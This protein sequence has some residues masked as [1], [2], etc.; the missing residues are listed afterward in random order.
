VRAVVSVRTLP[1]I[2]LGY[3]YVVLGD[4]VASAGVRIFFLA[5]ETRRASRHANGRERAE[6]QRHAPY[7]PSLSR[8]KREHH[9][10][11]D[12]ELDEQAALEA[13]RR[14]QQ[15]EP[16]RPDR[17]RRRVRQQLEAAPR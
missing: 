11:P 12:D 10:T 16:R 17:P 3:Q 5:D 14:E 4:T 9:E 15:H 1:N 6:S 13:A 7:R 2:E 8:Q